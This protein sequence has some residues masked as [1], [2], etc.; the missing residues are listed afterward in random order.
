MDKTQEMISGEYYLH[1]VHEMA[2]GFKIEA[3]KTF[4]FFFCYGAL[5]RYGSGTYD[6]RENQIIFKSKDWPGSDFKL[7]GSQMSDYDKI[8]IEV[9]V[10][11]QALARSIYASLDGGKPDS[12]YSADKDGIILFDKQKIDSISLAL[13]FCPERFSVQ[14]V[15]HSEHNYFKFSIEPWIFEYYFN[16]FALYFKDSGLYGGHPFLEGKNFFYSKQK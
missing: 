16:D 15:H 13:E 6:F 14:Q 10:N 11:N 8:V 9:L 7:E 1:G 12:W 3:D 2:S 5:D 4:D